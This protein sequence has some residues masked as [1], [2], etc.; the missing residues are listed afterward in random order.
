MTYARCLVEIDLAKDLT[1]S[2]SL[3]LPGGVEYEQAIFYENLPRFCP[4]CRMMGHTKES[5]KTSKASTK[6]V[7]TAKPAG[8]NSE[9]GKELEAAGPEEGGKQSLNP[10]EGTSK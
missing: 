3:Q 2:T 8:T 5:C 9:K 1:H 10:G 7:I 6:E 4:Q